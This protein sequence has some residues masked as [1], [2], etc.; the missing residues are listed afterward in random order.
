[1]TA[2]R[3]RAPL[4]GLLSA[5]L[6]SQTGTAMSALAIPWL[7][8][9]RTGSATQT[10]L[11]GFAEM[12]PYVL[13]QA[14]AGPLADRVGLRRACVVGNAGAALIVCAIPALYA[15]GALKFGVLLALIAI[16]GAIRGIADAAASP[17]VPAMARLGAVGLERAAGLLSA[18]NRTGLLLGMP[19]AGL[20]IGVTSAPTVVLI[21]GVTFAVAAIL[22]AAFVPVAAEPVTDATDAMTPRRYAA[23]LAEGLRF[24]RADR[25]LLGIVSMVAVTNLLNQALSSVLL[26]V[27]VRTRLHDASGLGF[28]GGAMSVGLLAGV[29]LG[30]WLGHRLPRRTTYAV[31]FLISGAPPLFALAFADSLPPVIAVCVVAGVAGGVLNPIIGAVSYER[32]PPALQARVLGA[33]KASA[34]VGIPIGSLTAGPLTGAVGL[35]AALLTTGAA[36]FATTLAPFVFPV[37]RESWGPAKEHW[38]HARCRPVRHPCADALEDVPARGGSTPGDRRRDPARR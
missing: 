13:L 27:W 17:L 15:A 18:A 22:I 11:V 5:Y 26:P 4:Y 8:L 16:A 38:T 7:V 21:D 20:L 25:L 35:R 6:I 37:W 10:G 2:S 23:E 28:V 29:L 14:T 3:R 9:T 1:V 30:A 36:M 31:G 24:L 33:V 12:A 34:W 19:L 32:V